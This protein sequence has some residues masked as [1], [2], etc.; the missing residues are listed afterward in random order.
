MRAHVS[1][2]VVWIKC[3]QRAR[4]FAVMRIREATERVNRCPL[5]EASQCRVQSRVCLYACNVRLS[6]QADRNSGTTATWSV[7]R[8]LS[9]HYNI[10]T[11]TYTYTYNMLSPTAGHV[12]TVA[13]SECRTFATHVWIYVWWFMLISLMFEWTFMKIIIN[14]CLL[15]STHI[16]LYINRH[17]LMIF[18]FRNYIFPLF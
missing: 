17:D 12:V 16:W 2:C 7:A 1:S 4:I 8:S 3:I 5:L 13:S 11:Y 15:D 9:T 18:C 6:T 10:Y 14:M